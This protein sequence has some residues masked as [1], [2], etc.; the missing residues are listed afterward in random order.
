MKKLIVCSLALSLAAFGAAPAFAVGSLA[1]GHGDH[2]GW[3]VNHATQAEAD[4]AAL[5]ACTG[6][7]EVVYQF[8]NTCAA[9]ARE[10][11]KDNGATGWAHADSE[12]AAQARALAECNKRGSDCV[13]KVWGCDGK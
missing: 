1:V 12:D 4:R 7:C 11:G 10:D 9:F 13:I 5:D 8:E 6:E 2:Y 3:A